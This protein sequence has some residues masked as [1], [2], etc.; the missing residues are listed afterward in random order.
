MDFDFSNDQQ[1]LR[2]TV[3]KWVSREYSF[4]DRQ[5]LVGAGGFSATAWRGLA[6]LGLLGLQI[7]EDCGGMGLGAVDAMVVMEELGRGLV[8]EP[9]AQGALI[10]PHLLG[11]APAKIR[12]RYL[13][14]IG[15]GEML[16]VLAHQERAA[17]YRLNRVTTRA[18]LS[19][20]TWLLNGAKGIVPAG[21]VAN[22][23]IVPAR[24]TGADDDVSGLA[25]FLVQRDGAGIEARAY[26]ALDGSSA[27]EI[28]FKNTPA[29][30]LVGAEDGSNAV[31]NMLESAVDV[32]IAALCA[33]AVGVMESLLA[34]TVEYMNMRKQFG[35]PI[36]S[37]QA[38][39]HR[40]ADIK[41]QLELARSMSYLATLRL[42]DQ[43]N[44]RRRALAQAKLQLGRSMRFVGQQC[45]QIH[46]GIGLTDE[47][48][49]SHYFKRL[50]VIEMTFGDTLHQLV[51]VSNRMESTAGVY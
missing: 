17:R 3:S 35:V 45:L 50:T 37:F 28:G 25:L 29:E 20:D 22:A 41:L 1:M 7:A 15:A 19:G 9:Y 32:G 51:E 23:F 16:V 42:D 31:F 30:L 2:E 46:G 48:V 18:V 47:Y 14:A 26:G 34:T 5:K 12:Q 49:A 6:E 43:P 13:P 27:A 8:L 36:A 24:V 39:R 10:S 40:I 38:L 4:E 33:E 44:V 21:S 11:F